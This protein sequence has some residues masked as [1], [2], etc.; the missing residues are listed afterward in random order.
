MEWQMKYWSTS[1]CQALSESDGASE[2]IEGS[3]YVDTYQICRVNAYDQSL[4]VKFHGEWG[5][6]LADPALDELIAQCT[7]SMR[8]RKVGKGIGK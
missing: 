4:E 8:E 7:S 3:E 2:N 6:R 5:S 1:V